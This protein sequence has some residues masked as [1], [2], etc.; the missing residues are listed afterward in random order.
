MFTI[1]WRGLNDL[2]KIY[3]NIV[4]EACENI[5]HSLTVWYI[6]LFRIINFSYSPI[7][8]GINKL[9]KSFGSINRVHNPDSNIFIR[10]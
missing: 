2:V 6:D 9:L 5:N 1:L 8:W 4:C 7:N 10:I 3:F